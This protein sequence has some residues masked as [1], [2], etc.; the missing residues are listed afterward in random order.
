MS[1]NTPNRL[2]IDVVRKQENGVKLKIVG[3]DKKEMNKTFSR[4]ATVRDIKQHFIEEQGL[5]EMKK[6]TQN[7]SE[8]KIYCN[9]VQISNES[10]SLNDLNIKSNFRISQEYPSTPWTVLVEG[11]N[12]QAI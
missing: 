4:F 1:P 6:Q 7:I 9:D 10:Q 8:M 12:M 2:L 11:L 3:P 5:S